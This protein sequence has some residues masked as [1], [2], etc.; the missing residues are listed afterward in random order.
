MLFL[1]GVVSAQIELNASDTS[2]AQQDGSFITINVTGVTG[3]VTFEI[4]PVKDESNKVINLH[5]IPLLLMQ[6]V[7]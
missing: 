7:F 4:S 1:V 5:Y 6:M 3:N 2:F